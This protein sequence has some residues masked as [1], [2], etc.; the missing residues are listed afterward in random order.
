VKQHITVND[1][2]S[3]YLTIQE[4]FKLIDLIKVYPNFSSKN[5]ENVDDVWEKEVSEALTIGKMIE[6]LNDKL[7]ISCFE[8]FGA[9]VTWGVKND[10]NPIQTTDIELCNALWEVLTK[11][12]K[13]EGGE[14]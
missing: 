9:A 10:S 4:K 14:K 5:T 3:A 2:K 13:R 6:I 12:I 7:I 8:E 1:L 11:R